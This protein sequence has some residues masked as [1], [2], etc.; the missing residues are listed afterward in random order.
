M[1]FLA[2]ITSSLS[3]MQPAKAFLEES[4]GINKIKSTGLVSA[5]CFLGSLFVIWFSQNLVALN[6]IDFWVGT[7]LIFIMAAVQIICFG[8]VF[9]LERGIREAEEGGHMKI[10]K[11]FHFVIKYVSPTYL[12]IVFVGFCYQALPGY[13]TQI[14]G[15]PVVQYTL[16]LIAAIVVG[17]LLVTRMGAKRW[18]ASNMDLDGRFPPD[19]EIMA[20]AGRRKP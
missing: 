19:D 13:M 6:T 18:K 2:A 20:P 4:L 14:G 3:M 15:N 7:F 5:V 9:G 17:L 16:G 1:L 8:W 12:I 11:L 10:P